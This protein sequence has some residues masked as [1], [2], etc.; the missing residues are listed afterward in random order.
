M[1]TSYI[2]DVFTHSSLVHSGAGILRYLT[3]GFNPYQVRLFRFMYS[4]KA[5][6]T[7]TD[8]DSENT[9]ALRSDSPPSLPHVELEA[10]GRSGGRTPR[11]RPARPARPAR[12]TPKNHSKHPTS[13]TASVVAGPTVKPLPFTPT[14]RIKTALSPCDLPGIKC[15]VKNDPRLNKYMKRDGGGLVKRASIPGEPRTFKTDI[16]LNG[17]TVVSKAYWTSDK[18]FV[19]TETKSLTRKFIDYV[20]KDATT[21]NAFKLRQTAIK[22][23]FRDHADYVT[24]HVIEVSERN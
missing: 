23:R 4:A 13:K 6:Q 20:K 5:M 18:L 17:V 14:P 11:K 1:I 12:P 3:G 10:R 24:E 21:P 16:G 19:N 2:Y 9:L 8:R 15:V 22:P 7:L